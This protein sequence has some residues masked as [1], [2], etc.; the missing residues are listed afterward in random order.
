MTSISGL[1][2]PVSEVGTRSMILVTLIDKTALAF[3]GILIWL[4][5]RGRG[6][7]C[8]C[9]LPYVCGRASCRTTHLQLAT[10]AH[11]LPSLGDATALLL[12]L[13]LVA[14]I[15]VTIR[16]VGIGQLPFFELLLPLIEQQIETGLVQIGWLLLIAVLLRLLVGR[17]RLIEAVALVVTATI[18]IVA[19]WTRVPTASLIGKSLVTIVIPS[20]VLAAIVTKVIINIIAGSSTTS[21][22]TVLALLASTII[23]KAAK[24]ASSCTTLILAIVTVAIIAKIGLWI[25][26]EWVLALVSI[27][28][29]ITPTIA[30]ILDAI[31]L[32]VSPH[33]RCIDVG[34]DSLPATRAGI[35][36]AIVLLL[37]VLWRITYTRWWS[38]H[39]G[40]LVLIL[41]IGIRKAWRWFAHPTI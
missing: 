3:E 21:S 36:A 15:L 24:V 9:F 22:K 14:S 12:E 5:L 11:L 20:I 35:L 13:L 18:W 17:I 38:A 10:S 41:L 29:S 4:L 25:L 1:S 8:G 30:A 6:C 16:M 40:I 37:M 39:P 33:W 31:W 28:T 7:T 26:N 32:V 34:I 27:S 19:A 2:V 23:S